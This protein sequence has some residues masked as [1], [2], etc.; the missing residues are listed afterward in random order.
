MLQGDNWCLFC[1]MI[2]TI[3]MYGRG[4]EFISVEAGCAYR[5]NCF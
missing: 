4:A 1:Q 2:N 5:N 3:S